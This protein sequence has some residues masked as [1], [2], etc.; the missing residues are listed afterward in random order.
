[1]PDYVY[2][3]FAAFALLLPLVLLFWLPV[4]HCVIHYWFN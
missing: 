2:V 3:A 4:T 1:M